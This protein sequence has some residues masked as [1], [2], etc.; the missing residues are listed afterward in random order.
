MEIWESYFK[1]ES[2]K[3][4][5][6]KDPSIIDIMVCCQQC[7]IETYWQILKKQQQQCSLCVFLGIKID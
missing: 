1:L 7:I 3:S 6:K 4:L 5:E 2:K